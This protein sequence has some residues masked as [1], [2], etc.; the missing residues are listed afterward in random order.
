MATVIRMIDIGRAGSCECRG[1]GHFAQQPGRF[2]TKTT[3]NAVTAKSSRDGRI[4]V[5]CDTVTTRTKRP[6]MEDPHAEH[7]LRSVQAESQGL[8]GISLARRSSNEGRTVQ[9]RTRRGTP[10]FSE[11]VLACRHRLVL[12]VFAGAVV[13]SALVALSWRLT[14]APYE[15]ESLVRVRQHQEVVFTPQTSRADDVAFV[16]AQEQLVRSPQVLA[17]ALDDE[18]VRAL[19]E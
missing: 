10:E 4:H 14:D 1:S 5:G 11:L 17:A 19:L 6:V 18:Q 16:R 13:S 12:L 7:G 8:G 9:S 15:A 3:L 2:V